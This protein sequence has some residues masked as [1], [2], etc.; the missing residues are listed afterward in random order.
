MHVLVFCE[1][2]SLNG[3]ERSLL[4][5]AQRLD[6]Q[7]FQFTIAAPAK[8]PLGERL[9]QCG[10]EHAAFE[11]F[12]EHAARPPRAL[13]RQNAARLISR[14]A[15][16]VVHANSLSM[17]R[18]LGPVA[19]EL[20][21]PS[22]GHLRDIIR[23][24]RS[25]IV[26]LNHHQCLLAVSAA[27]RDWYV[28][29]GLAAA[30][31]VVEYNGI[32]LQRFA[33]R[34]AGKFLHLQLEIPQRIRLVGCVGQIGVRKGMDTFIEAASIVAARQPDV[35]FLIVGQR[36]SQKPEAKTYE[37]QLREAASRGAL[38][39]RVHFLGIRD[40]IDLILNEM[41]LYVHAARQEPL[42]RVL[43]EA[44]ASGTP[45]VATDV[46]GT[47]EIFPPDSATALLVSPSAPET[48]AQAILQL[49][50]DPAAARKMGSLARERIA[51]LFDAETAA[52]R[53][54]GHYVRVACRRA[55]DRL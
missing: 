22:M 48:L 13:L 47:R 34:A 37:R 20:A 15:P 36:Y 50:D 33:P 27:T 42:G 45:I 21:I 51:R 14:V 17:S 39:G 18:L 8:G 26:D 29:A 11:L 2:A 24:S 54:A 52:R 10:L 12:D 19:R 6:K 43:L 31:T 7:N 5:V 32:D 9:H 38:I 1:Y 40:D 25:S 49:L 28:S 41:T 23:V 55:S 30:R 3:G 35:H 46:G 16:A 53:L 4:E 44:G